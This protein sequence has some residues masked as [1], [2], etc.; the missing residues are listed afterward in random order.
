MTKIYRRDNTVQYL[1]YYLVEFEGYE[2]VFHRYNKAM[3]FCWEHD[4][5][6]NKELKTNDSDVYKRCK[7]L[8]IQR[9]RD[10]DIIKGYVQKLFKA[11]CD[12]SHELAENRD[13]IEL[14]FGKSRSLIAQ[15]D[16]ELAQE[17]VLKQGGK[18]DGVYE[19]MLL[20][21]NMREEYFG[22]VYMADRWSKKK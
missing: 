6:P 16:Y 2:Y 12:K 1:G 3:E 18:V 11:T 8:A 19:S 15:V 20:I 21:D 10:L 4:L 14:K 13:S 17:A 22:V 9:L 7:D 5:D